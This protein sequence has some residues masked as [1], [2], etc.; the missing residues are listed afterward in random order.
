MIIMAV[1]ETVMIIMAVGE[2]TLLPVEDR[3]VGGVE[4]EDR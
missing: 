3:V 1:G 4:V 2:T